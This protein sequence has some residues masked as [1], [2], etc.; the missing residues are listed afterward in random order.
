MLNEALARYA[1]EKEHENTPDDEHGEA[2]IKPAAIIRRHD[3]RYS[4]WGCLD[5]DRRTNEQDNQLD[6]FGLDIA[7]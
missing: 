3:V 4:P 1:D 6:D 2:W 5:Y 7:R